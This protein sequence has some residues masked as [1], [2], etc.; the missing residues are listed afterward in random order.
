MN[1]EPKAQRKADGWYAVIEFPNGG[2]QV[3]STRHGTM[4][5]AI[6]EADHALRIRVHTPEACVRDPQPNE[7]QE[8]AKP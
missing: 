4:D 5:A 2:R 6:A 8:I 3:F 1:L 7:Y